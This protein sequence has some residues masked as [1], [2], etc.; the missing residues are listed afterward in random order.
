[1]VNMKD[2]G[3]S[4]V[5]IEDSTDD[6]SESDDRLPRGRHH[7]KPWWEPIL[8]MKFDDP[9]QEAPFWLA[10]NNAVLNTPFP[11]IQ[12]KAYSL[13]DRSQ[14]GVFLSGPRRVNVMMIQKYLR[15]ERDSL[16][17]AL[18]KGTEINAGNCLIAVTEFGLESD[19]EKKEW[20]VKTLNAFANVLRPRL[21]KWYQESIR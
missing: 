14:V 21:R 6:T 1:M 2:G 18:L 8:K 13:K 17:R 11:G 3:G 7:L 9:E 10:T 12:I 15:R 16:M 20:I 5:I 4:Q 19:D